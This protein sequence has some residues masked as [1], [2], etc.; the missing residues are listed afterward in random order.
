[1]KSDDGEYMDLPPDEQP[2][3]GRGILEKED[4]ARE[5]NRWHFRSDE[6][7]VRDILIRIITGESTYDDLPFA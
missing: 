1:D 4:A 5:I 3:S 2:L 7:R 6:E